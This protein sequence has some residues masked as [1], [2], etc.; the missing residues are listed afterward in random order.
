MDDER[1]ILMQIDLT[2]AEAWRII[3]AIIAYK[4][5]YHVSKTVQKTIANVEKKIKEAIENE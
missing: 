3:D 5:D 4:E 1:G 2:K